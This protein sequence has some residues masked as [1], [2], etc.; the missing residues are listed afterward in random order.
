MLNRI[1]RISTLVLI[2]LL[3]LMIPFGFIIGPVSI[4][5]FACW[6][7][8]GEWKMK[9]QNLKSANFLWII[10]AFFLLNLMSLLWTSNSDAGNFNIQ[11]KLLLFGLPIVIASLR[12]DAKQTRRL[13][14]VFISGLAVC[15]LLMLSRSFYYY[16]S[17][18]RN[19]FYYQDFC[20]RVVHP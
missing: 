11:V 14:S 13:L 20:H 12:F 9:W 19:T 3:A 8:S 4:V 6:I 7:L 17:E 18:G 5:L 15:G 16:F 1:F 10:I 2:H